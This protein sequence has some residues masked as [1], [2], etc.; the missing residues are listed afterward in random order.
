MN[1]DPDAPC[2]NITYPVYIAV[3]E[4]SRVESNYI[5]S[6]WYRTTNDTGSPPWYE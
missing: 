4:V 3:S 5:A 1:Y 6:T 2:L